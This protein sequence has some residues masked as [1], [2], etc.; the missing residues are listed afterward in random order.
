MFNTKSSINRIHSKRQ[1]QQGIAVSFIS[2]YF[3][4]IIWQHR[5]TKVVAF[6]HL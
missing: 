1:Q 4:G 6:C 2:K 5:T 3:M